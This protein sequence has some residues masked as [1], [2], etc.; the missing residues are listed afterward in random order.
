MQI[1]SGEHILKSEYIGALSVSYRLYT[2]ELTQTVLS[3]SSTSL[4]ISLSGDT[5]LCHSLSG[6]NTLFC[7]RCDNI[8]VSAC[9]FTPNSDIETM[10]L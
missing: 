2:T 7:F 9:F 5:G 8:F 1:F 4:F 10:F 6:H 3:N